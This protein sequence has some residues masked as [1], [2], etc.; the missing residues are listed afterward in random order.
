[1]K[2]LTV[3]NKLKIIQVS[4]VLLAASWLLTACS[5][6]TMP[7]PVLPAPCPPNLTTDCPL[8]PPARSGRLTDLLD[9]HI[10][11]MELYAQCRSQLHQLAR[12]ANPQE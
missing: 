11:A 5:S 7:M 1:M 4:V 8:P 12:C 9:N 10:E 6:G 3:V 2:R